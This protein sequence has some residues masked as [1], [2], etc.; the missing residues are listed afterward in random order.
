LPRRWADYAAGVHYY[1]NLVVLRT[2]TV[3][4]VLL[5]AGVIL[6]R[7]EERLLA[8]NAYRKKLAGKIARGVTQCVGQ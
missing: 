6:N 5:E 4:A 7:G 1:D 2:A 3:P 8:Q